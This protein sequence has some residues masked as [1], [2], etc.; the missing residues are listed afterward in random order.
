M[1]FPSVL[2]PSPH[3]LLG[4]LQFCRLWRWENLFGQLADRGKKIYREQWING[5]RRDGDDGPLLRLGGRNCSSAVGLKV[6]FAE[7]N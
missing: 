6:G 5:Y 1:Y 3:V 7:S 2:V 4:S